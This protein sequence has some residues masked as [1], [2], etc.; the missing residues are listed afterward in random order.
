[1][2]AQQS[3]TSHDP[4]QGVDQ[5]T[6]GKSP[7]P[8]QVT[9]RA[10]A[11]RS[12]KGAGYPDP[13]LLGWSGKSTTTT[14]RS[15]GGSWT[16]AD[17]TGS[18]GELAATPPG[19]T[20]PRGRCPYSAPSCSKRVCFLFKQGWPLA[21]R[22]SHAWSALQDL[23]R[24]PRPSFHGLQILA[25]PLIWLTVLKASF[26]ICR[27]RFSPPKSASAGLLTDLVSGTSSNG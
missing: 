19:G 3:K 21:K 13:E 22:T 5:A 6:C 20:A 23:S 10:A 15:G 16:A 8:R 4:R 9:G 24:Q 2:P 12:A 1:M 27:G 14:F 26:L 7:R 25:P 18:A 17:D 11:M